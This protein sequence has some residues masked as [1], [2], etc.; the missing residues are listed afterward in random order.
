MCAHA[1]TI[2]LNSLVDAM[3]KS[4]KNSYGKSVIEGWARLYRAHAEIPT[5]D[6]VGTRAHPWLGR[7]SPVNEAAPFIAGKPAPTQNTRAYDDK[8]SSI[9]RIHH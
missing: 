9:W 1:V 3:S 4:H 6:R 2:T 8:L 7:D 5:A